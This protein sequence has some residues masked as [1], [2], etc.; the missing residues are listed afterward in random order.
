MEYAFWMSLLVLLLLFNL[1]IVLVGKVM[2]RRAQWAKAEMTELAMKGR[3][4][5]HIAEEFK[6]QPFNLMMFDLTKWTYNQFYPQDEPN[7]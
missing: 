1:R 7:R 3:P 6:E 4:F 5:V 2:R